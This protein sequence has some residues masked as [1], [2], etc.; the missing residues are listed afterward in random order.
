MDLLGLLMPSFAFEFL[1]FHLFAARNSELKAIISLKTIGERLKFRFAFEA[2]LAENVMNS[3]PEMATTPLNSIFVFDFLLELA[4]KWGLE[5]SVIAVCVGS[6]V[7]WLGRWRSNSLKREKCRQRMEWFR[8]QV[9]QRR[10]LVRVWNHANRILNVQSAD[11]LEGDEL[12]RNNMDVT[13]QFL[14]MRINQWGVNNEIDGVRGRGL[15]AHLRQELW[16]DW[17][18]LVAD[19]AA[20]DPTMHII[21]SAVG[22]GR[23]RVASRRNR[24]RRRNDMAVV[25]YAHRDVVVVGDRALVRVHDVEL[26][27]EYGSDYDGDQ[28]M[29]ED[30]PEELID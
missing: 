5:H 12:A 3:P 29:Y 21:F 8:A 22:R 14:R 23:R 4:G 17:T 26:D 24:R 19:V 25:P 28:L 27:S 7:Y 10:L 16:A 2:F 9:E 13:R 15:R 6:A 1:C 11:Y 18:N 30:I 20:I